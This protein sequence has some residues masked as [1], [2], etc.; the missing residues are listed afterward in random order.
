[1]ASLRGSFDVGPLEALQAVA[2]QKGTGALAVWG[3]HRRF[4]FEFLEGRIVRAHPRRLF[5]LGRPARLVRLLRE[6]EILDPDTE[7]AWR[8]ALRTSRGD[9]LDVLVAVRPG[10]A[11]ILRE[12]YR[13]YVEGELERLL[14]VV[15]GRFRFRPRKQLDVPSCLEPLPM[16]T[17]LLEAIRRRDEVRELLQGPLALESLPVAVRVPETADAL[18]LEDRIRRFVARS[19]QG[20]WKIRELLARSAIPPSRILETLAAGQAEGWIRLAGSP[21]PPSWTVPGPG[22]SE[23]FRGR[24]AAAL[25]L[26]LLLAATAGSWILGEAIARAPAMRWGRAAIAGAAVESLDAR[27]G[28]ALRRE[29]RRLLTRL[30]HVDGPGSTP[31]PPEGRPPR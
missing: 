18:G 19:S 10:M 30:G 8:Q 6:L 2:L 17:V 9:P 27:R 16:E 29:A 26:G 28:E 22:G 4:L 3:Q 7:E 23:G 14:E 31:P 11:P 13:L 25:S 15:R 12:A 20:G 24:L 5:P 21:Q 1:M